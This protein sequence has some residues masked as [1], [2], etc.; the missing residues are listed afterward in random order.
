M[1]KNSNEKL[2]NKIEKEKKTVKIMILKYCKGKK[3]LEIP[4][5]DCQELIQY[6]ENRI[7]NCP[8][9]ETKTYCTNCEVHCYSPE[10]RKSIREVM[11][12]SG[13][14]MIFSHPIIAMDHLYQGIK[15]KLKKKDEVN[16]K[17]SNT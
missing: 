16:D 14:R 13:P 10:M 9:M 12:Y 6:T 11:R 4:C 2:A 1:S 15:Y 17:N 3:H 7:E 5:K 8:F